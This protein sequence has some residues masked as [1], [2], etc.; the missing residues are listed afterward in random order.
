MN[1]I[2]LNLKLIFKNLKLSPKNALLKSYPLINSNEV[3]CAFILLLSIIAGI[4]N[5]LIQKYLP[6]SLFKNIDHSLVQYNLSGIGGQFQQNYAPDLT[7]YFFIGFILFYIVLVICAGISYIVRTNLF[8]TQENI[9]TI[10]KAT[11]ISLIPAIIFLLLSSI[12]IIFSTI[13]YLIFIA[14][15]IAAFIIYFYQHLC[16]ISDNYSEKACFICSISL[17]AIIFIIFK[18]NV[19]TEIT[20]ALTSI[21]QDLLSGITGL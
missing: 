18:I 5:I 8:K 15:C 14:L 1:N 12:T 20:T 21:L 7:K 19:N 16:N 13:L 10:L 4:S 17:I 6:I 11:S 2:S 9:F 3:S